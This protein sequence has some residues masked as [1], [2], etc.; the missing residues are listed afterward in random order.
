MAAHGLSQVVASRGGRGRLLVAMASLV[1][2]PQGAR[3]SAVVVHRLMS[4]ALAGFPTTG[5]PG[6]SSP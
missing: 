6:K 3:A 2:E 5:P 4:P 1:A